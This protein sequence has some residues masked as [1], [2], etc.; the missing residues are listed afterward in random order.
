LATLIGEKVSEKLA[1]VG[2]VWLVIKP[3]GTGI[4]QEHTKLIGETAAEKVSGLLIKCDEE[5]GER[6][7]QQLSDVVERVRS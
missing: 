3:H 5:G 4:V 2:V 6:E 1:Q 7:R